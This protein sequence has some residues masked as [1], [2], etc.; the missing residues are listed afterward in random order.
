MQHLLVHLLRQPACGAQ[1]YGPAR[2]ARRPQPP[3]PLTHVQHPLGGRHLSAPPR[4]FA[5]IPPFRSAEKR[6]PLRAGRCERRRTGTEARSAWSFTA[7]P[8]ASERRRV[9]RVTSKS[10][11][12][13]TMTNADKDFIPL[14]TKD[15]PELSTLDFELKLKPQ[16]ALTGNPRCCASKRQAVTLL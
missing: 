6:R 3:A 13:R 15:F 8:A 12:K 1:R 5:R 16:N 10:R 11:T 14:L 7:T 9:P 4:K 2:P